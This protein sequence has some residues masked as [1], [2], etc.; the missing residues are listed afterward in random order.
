M[1]IQPP[2]VNPCLVQ[3]CTTSLHPWSRDTKFFSA[4]SVTNSWPAALCYIVSC[5]S[6]DQVSPAQKT[7]TSHDAGLLHDVSI[8]LASYTSQHPPRATTQILRKIPFITRTAIGEAAFLKGL[9]F[10]TR[11][12]F[13]TQLDPLCLA[14]V[15]GY[16]IGISLFGRYA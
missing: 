1:P 6:R 12:H 7:C 3:G 8:R 4:R 15:V 10:S 2:W 14:H 16:C 9:L 5:S 13:V 11:P